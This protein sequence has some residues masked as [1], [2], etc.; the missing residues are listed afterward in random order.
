MS[1][2]WDSELAAQ[3]AQQAY[4][5]V[6]KVYPKEAGYELLD[7][8]LDAAHAAQDAGDFAAFEDAL[9]NLMRTARETARSAA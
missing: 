8:H 6:A 5:Y 3:R 2:G 1:G 4:R 7:E 9:R